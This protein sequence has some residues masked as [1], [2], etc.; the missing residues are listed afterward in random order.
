MHGHTN[1]N[2]VILLFIPYTVTKPEQEVGLWFGQSSLN[3][4]S[5][6]ECQWQSFGHTNA[7]FSVYRLYKESIS[8]EMNKDDHQIVRLASQL[9][10]THIFLL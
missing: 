1:F 5:Q 6:G 3:N 7:N 9:V 8:N 10:T 2:W 4:A